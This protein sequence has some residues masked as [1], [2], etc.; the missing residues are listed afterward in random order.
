MSSCRGEML[1]ERIAMGWSQESASLRLGVALYKYIGF[2]NGSEHIYPPTMLK[3]RR[4]I[5][6]AK[7]E[8]KRDERHCDFDHFI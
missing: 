3:F 8:I 6:L 2:E 5:A 1:A 7:K 4:V